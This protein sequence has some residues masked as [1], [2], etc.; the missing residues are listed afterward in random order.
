MVDSWGKPPSGILSGHLAVPGDFEECISA[1]GRI[2]GTEE[3]IR[4]SYC[5]GVFIPNLGSATGE[6][7]KQGKGQ[8]SKN[9]RA[10][11]SP[12]E[13]LVRFLSNENFITT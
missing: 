3:K 9:S 8:L 5:L 4:G 10:A 12:A 11:L 7:K 6:T 1:R 2:S 13:L